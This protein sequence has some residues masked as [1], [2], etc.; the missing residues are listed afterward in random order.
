M[1][2]FS[3]LEKGVEV[4]KAVARIE[5]ADGSTGSGFL[6]GDNIL[7]TN[8][9][10]IPSPEVANQAKVQF[11]YQHT[12]QGTDAAVDPYDLAP[13]E[14]WKT[15]K[16]EEQG[17]DDWTAVKVKGNPKAKWGTLTL[18]TATPKAG[19]EVIIIQHPMGERKKI[20]L[21]HNMVAYADGKRVQYYTETEEGSSG[22]PVFDVE[23]RV[24]AV[25]YTGGWMHEPG[26]EASV[27]RNAGIN[28]N[29]VIE[30]AR[31][32]F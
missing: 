26:T 11:N 17:G 10:V 31:D 9:H 21:S 28:I 19:D 25:H 1:R 2:P 29:L 4:G 8:H 30:G 14:G 3:F 5:L 7:I 6:V 27:Y 32:L 15:S 12:I 24:V 23:W 20:A 18:I 13:G 16:K 22:S